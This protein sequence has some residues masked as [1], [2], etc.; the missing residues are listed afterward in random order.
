MF[1]FHFKYFELKRLYS[2]KLL[3]DEQKK[4]KNNVW[5]NWNVQQYVFRTSD[6]TLFWLL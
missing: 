1:T 5:D 3:R 6:Y 4:K 2:V